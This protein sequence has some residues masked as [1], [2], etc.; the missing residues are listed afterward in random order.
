MKKGIVLAITAVIVMSV[1][2]LASC[3]PKKATGTKETAEMASVKAAKAVEKEVMAIAKQSDAA[4]TAIKDVADDAFGTLNSGGDDAKKTVI[5]TAVKMV[6]DKLEDDKDTGLMKLS[7]AAVKK[8]EAV[9]DSKTKTSK[10]GM[11]LLTAKAVKAL[12]DMDSTTDEAVR[13]LAKDLNTALTDD[14]DY[15]GAEGT[16]SIVD[17]K[18]EVAALKVAVDA[19]KMAAGEA[20]KAAEAVKATK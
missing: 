16:N 18:A 1:V 10:A 7:A 4:S 15:T 5:M 11:S 12:V 6:M 17:R 9:K 20:V 3:D 14:P 2:L 13:K 8:A 19:L